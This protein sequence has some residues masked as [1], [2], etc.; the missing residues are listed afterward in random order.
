MLSLT[1][2][3]IWQP[4]YPPCKNRILYPVPDRRQRQEVNGIHLMLVDGDEVI[5]R[6]IMEAGLQP[7]SPVVLK[8][9]H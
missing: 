6:I 5:P 4:A 3:P 1:A 7:R 2:G 9:M 8:S